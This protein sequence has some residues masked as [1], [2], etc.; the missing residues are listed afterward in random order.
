MPA[1]I[2]FLR[3]HG[4]RHLLLLEDGV[5]AWTARGYPLER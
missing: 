3:R 1:D 4:Y 5:G 2:H